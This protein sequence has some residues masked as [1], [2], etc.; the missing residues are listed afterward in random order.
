MTHRNVS[1]DPPLHRMLRS[2]WAVALLA[3]VMA[4]LLEWGLI[5]RC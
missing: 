2:G 4:T 3:L 5:R 1:I